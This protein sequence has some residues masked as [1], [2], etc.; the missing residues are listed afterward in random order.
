[1][2][3]T[4][5][6]GRLYQKLIKYQKE[7]QQRFPDLYNVAD[8]LLKSLRIGSKLVDDEL[9]QLTAAANLEDLLNHAEKGSTELVSVLKQLIQQFKFYVPGGQ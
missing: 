3:M 4:E 2:L 8:N 1:M 9:Q 7:L 5:G 6:R